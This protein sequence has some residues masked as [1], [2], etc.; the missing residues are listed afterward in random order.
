MKCNILLLG[1]TG[2]GKSS[3][4]N[5]IA[6]KELAEAGISS[7]IGGITRGINKYSVDINGQMCEISDSEGLELSHSEY[8]LKLFNKELFNGTA[9]TAISDWYHI[10]IYCI[11][12]NGG[13]VQDFELEILDR[14]IDSGYGTIIAF[15]KADLATEEELQS[16]INIIQDHFIFSSSIQYIPICSKK[17]RTNRLEG[18]DELCNAIIDSWGESIA[19]RLPSYLFAW[20]FDSL[21]L[22][23]DST[24]ACLRTQK[25]GIFNKSK[26]EVLEEL[27][28]KIQ[29]KQGDLNQLIKSKQKSAFKDVTSVYQ[30]IS[31]II[32]VESFSA[33]NSD[34][35]PK[36]QKLQE[37]F[38]FDDH[39]VRKSLLTAASTALLFS[40]PFVGVPLTVLNTI[41]HF[42]DNARRL[43]ELTNAFNYQYLT[44]LKL[45]TERK[46][47]MEYLLAAQIG[48]IYARCE[49]AIC[50]LKGRGV[51][52]NFNTFHD[53]LEPLADYIENSETGYRN[54]K[55]EYYL[56]YLYYSINQGKEARK[57]L[58]MAKEDGYQN[59]RGVN[60]FAAMKDVEE[61]EEEAYEASFYD[62]DS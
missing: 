24:Q 50:Y 53:Y 60:S 20:A 55:V 11:G 9:K 36:L 56:A 16:M 43:E 18:R 58:K 4:L 28:R 51:E 47:F 12:A 19:N 2:V 30:A 40:V 7:H 48:Y 37:N 8:W 57:W 21:S 5:Y 45:F 1:Q 35:T 44:M 42:K 10:V 52:E 29:K 26:S 3:L 25:I 15:T 49:L 22:R 17:T 59:A 41:L 6:G 39:S 33:Y 61:Q 13:R 34:I 23:Y 14:I 38:V 62:L 27:N 31:Q 32:D 46:T 54:G